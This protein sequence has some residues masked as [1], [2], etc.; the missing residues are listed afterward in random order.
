MKIHTGLL[1]YD[2]RASIS[3]DRKVL[4]ASEA[5]ARRFG[6]APDTCCVNPSDL[7]VGIEPPQGMCIE[8]VTLVRPSHFL[9]GV[10]G[11]R[12]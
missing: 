3:F 10:S 4:D 5:Y 1:W 2:N 9:V 6:R 12:R 7:P 11:Q 8:A